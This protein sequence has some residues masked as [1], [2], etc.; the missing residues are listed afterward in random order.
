M[1]E[2]PSEI[3]VNTVTIKFW[4]RG[5]SS[6]TPVRTRECATLNDAVSYWERS[7]YSTNFI[8]K[9]YDTAKG[10]HLRDLN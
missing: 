6:V 4:P 2:M 5:E 3:K 9:V 10:T 1:C 8:G 7:H